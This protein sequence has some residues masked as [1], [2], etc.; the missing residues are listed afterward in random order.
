M[1]NPDNFSDLV[2]VSESVSLYIM[3]RKRCKKLN[4]DENYKTNLEESKSSLQSKIFVPLH[5]L[6]DD[7][8]TNA[9]FIDNF[10]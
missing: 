1:R 3:D 2:K 7:G 5:K 8:K 9:D 6:L 4:F 10:K